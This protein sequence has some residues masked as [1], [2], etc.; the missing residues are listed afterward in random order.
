M[1]KLSH[2]A[3]LFLG[4]VLLYSLGNWS[5]PLIDRDEPRFAEASREMRQSG[6]LIVPRLN[7]AYRFDKPPLIYWCQVAAFACFGE[8]DFAAR[9]PSALFAAGAAVM[10]AAWATRL[11]GPKIGFWAGLVFGTCLQVFIHGR[12]GVADMPMVFFFLTAAWIGWE[13]FHGADS[14]VLWLCF[15]SSLALGFLAKGPVALLP[16]LSAP[17]S[18]WIS[19]TRYRL[20]PSSALL[21]LLVTAFIIAL[22]GIPALWM[23]H[24]EFFKVGIGKHVLM[25]SIEPMESHG[26]GGFLGYLALLPFYLVSIF[27]SFFPWWVFLPGTLGHLR[28]QRG[29]PENYLLCTIVPVWLIFTLIQTK[30]PHY[31][32]PCLPMLSIL[33]ARQV[34]ESRWAA[35]ILGTTSVIYLGVALIGFPA[36]A[37]FFPSPAIVG[38]VRQDLS[39]DMRTASLGYDEPSLI[40]YLRSTTKA[41]HVRLA[42]GEFSHFMTAAGPA[43]CVVSKDNLR[44]LT[45]DP[46]WRSFDS[47]GYNFAR[48]KWQRKELLG[49]AVSLPLPQPVDLVAFLKE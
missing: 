18:A 3:L 40:W 26:G 27:F 5:L 7:G 13:R 43:I 12:A 20:Q 22:W 35:S 44:L 38:A 48:W 31:I 41:F 10:T 29:L 8:S 45:I 39:A 14:R 49:L 24:G 46:A 4:L 34:A 17:L 25:R 36:I 33:V 37:P 19:G 2:L 30:L 16:M 9:F 47:Q 42:P 15:Y 1:I 6:D 23:T 21:G 32:L 11:Y 28:V